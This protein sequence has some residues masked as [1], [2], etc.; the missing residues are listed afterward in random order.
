[1]KIELL[2]AVIVG[3]TQ[4][5]RRAGDVVEVDDAEGEALIAV[6]HAKATTKKLTTDAENLGALNDTTRLPA[7]AVDGEGNPI[8]NANDNAQANTEANR[9]GTKGKPTEAK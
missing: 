9:A 8:A 2:T 5:P 6:G 7:G 4:V 1:M 3:T